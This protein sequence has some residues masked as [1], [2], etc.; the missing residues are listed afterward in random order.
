MKTISY[1]S[2]VDLWILTLFCMASVVLLFAIRQ[3]YFQKNL[4]S[5]FMMVYL[6]MVLAV[7]WLPVFNTK[8][9]FNDTHLIVKC[10]FFRWKIKL[11]NIKSVETIRDFGAAPALSVDRVQIQY[12]ENGVKKSL[13]IS[14][15]N[16][17][18]FISRLSIK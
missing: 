12:T 11:E 18:D 9:T 10:L 14:P 2:K 6:L 1:S 15:V 17:T 5:S 3:C 4:F 16:L 7:I 8:Y 13:S